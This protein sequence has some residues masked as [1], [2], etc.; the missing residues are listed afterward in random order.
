LDQRES[1]FHFCIRALFLIAS[2]RIASHRTQDPPP[3]CNAVQCSAPQSDRIASHRIHCIFLTP[4]DHTPSRV[5]QQ[6]NT[7][8]H[9]TPRISLSAL[10]VAVPYC[11]CCC[12]CICLCLPSFS[13]FLM[14]PFFWD[15]QKIK[16]PTRPIPAKNRTIWRGR[17][18]VDE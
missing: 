3:P 17:P 18:E 9:D 1:F 15:T 16:G 7:T 11:C 10:V 2:H 8:R 5:V 13:S 4:P 12:C 6:T 14:S